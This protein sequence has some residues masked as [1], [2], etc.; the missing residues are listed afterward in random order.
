MTRVFKINM[1]E[2][3]FKNKKNL[4]VQD[5]D[6]LIYLNNMDKLNGISQESLEKKGH[7]I[8]N[9]WCEDTVNDT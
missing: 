8:L 9:E 7:I 1:Y 5:V 4:S 2:D 3:W 6:N